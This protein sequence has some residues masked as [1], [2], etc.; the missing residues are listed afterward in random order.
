MKEYEKPTVE[1][2]DFDITE[3]IMNEEEDYNPDFS[4]GIEDW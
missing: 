2:V 4:A 1:I 3:L